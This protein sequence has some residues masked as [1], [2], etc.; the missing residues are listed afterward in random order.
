MDDFAN[1]T[2]GNLNKLQYNG[3]FEIWE[4]FATETNILAVEMQARY[5]RD[6]MSLEANMDVI[7]SSINKTIRPTVSNNRFFAISGGGQDI[8]ANI[9]E[10]FMDLLAR[11]KDIKNTQ[12]SR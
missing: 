9:V 12:W 3:L 2:S 5:I 8:E 11:E 4:S 6:L 7:A 10:Y 1:T